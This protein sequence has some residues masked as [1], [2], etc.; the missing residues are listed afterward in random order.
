MDGVKIVDEFH[1]LIDVDRPIDPKAQRVHGITKEMLAG[2]PRA[3]EVMPRFRSFI[4]GS[5]MIA[6]SADFDMSFIDSEFRRLKLDFRQPYYCTLTLVR[7]M[8]PELEGYDLA[9]LYLHFYGTRPVLTH[10]ALDDAVITAAIWVVIYRYISAA[11]FSC[12]IVA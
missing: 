6:H 1:S 4:E 12:Q 3:E 11:P 9:N 10:R 8:F 2:Q 7:K 5:I